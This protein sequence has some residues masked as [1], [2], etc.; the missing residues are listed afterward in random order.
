MVKLWKNMVKHRSNL[1]LLGFLSFSTSRFIWRNHRGYRIYIYIYIYINLLLSL[2]IYTLVRVLYCISV[3]L[4][5][6]LPITPTC[7]F[8]H[9]RDLEHGPPPRGEMLSSTNSSNTQRNR[10]WEKKTQTQNSTCDLPWLFI[11]LPK[12]EYDYMVDMLILV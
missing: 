11:L 12:V 8:W 5:L 7:T 3:I 10:K 6:L 1:G 9:L 4:P 2:Y